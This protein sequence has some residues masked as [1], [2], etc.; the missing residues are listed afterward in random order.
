MLER[1][2]AALGVEPLQLFSVTAASHKAL[3]S[4]IQQGI[5]DIKQAVRETIQDAL[6]GE[7]K[8]KV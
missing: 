4:L 3:E 7:C 2:A 8:D 6:A 5:T 1:L